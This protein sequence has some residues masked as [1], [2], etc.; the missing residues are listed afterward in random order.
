MVTALLVILAAAYTYAGVNGFLQERKSGALE[1]I[2]V[3]PLSVNQIIFG[4]IWGLWTQFLPAALLLVGSD[5]AVQ[6]MIPQSPYL[7]NYL[8]PDED[9]FWAR[10]I[11]IVA[12][13]L[14]LPVVATC[15]ALSA[16]H[17]FTASVFTVL[18]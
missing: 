5:I 16:K 4:R 11:E 7:G 6:K 12:I 10:N 13:Y 3:S 17:L 14:T 8:F 9:W 15:F 18:M 1:L 2:L